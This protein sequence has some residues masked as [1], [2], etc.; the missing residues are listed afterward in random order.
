MC[1][2]LYGTFNVISTT[3][4]IMGNACCVTLKLILYILTDLAIEKWLL[5]TFSLRMFMF[6][7]ISLDILLQLNVYCTAHLA[8]FTQPTKGGHFINTDTI[9]SN[10]TFSVRING[11]DCTSHPETNYF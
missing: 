7:L 8:K 3:H 11:F 2:V 5:C 10:S 9:Y 6:Y 4:T 1:T